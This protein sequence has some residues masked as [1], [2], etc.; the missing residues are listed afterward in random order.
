MADN[1]PSQKDF[2]EWMV[3]KA[4]AAHLGTKN[5]ENPQRMA[6]LFDLDVRTPA[7]ISKL[8]EMCGFAL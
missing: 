2:Q 8:K 4:L 5:N 6:W 7:G 3:T 1:E